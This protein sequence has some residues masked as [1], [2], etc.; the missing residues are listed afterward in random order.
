M[1]PTHVPPRVAGRIELIKKMVFP[2]MKDQSIGVVHPV[3]LRREVRLWSESFIH[4]VRR[5]AVLLQSIIK[6]ESLG[7]LIRLDNVVNIDMTPSAGGSVK[8]T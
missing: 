3:D 6:I 1:S 4:V 2:I 8:D 5:Q 7:R